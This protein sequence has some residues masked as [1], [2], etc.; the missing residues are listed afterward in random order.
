MLDFGAFSI[1]A[2]DVYMTS[3]T[4]SIYDKRYRDLIN[5]LIEQRKA[6]K[7][8]Q[9][10]VADRLGISRQN[11]SKIETGTRRVDVIELNDWLKALG[12]KVDLIKT[13]MS[14]V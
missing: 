13:V 4:P 5:A 6:K 10:Q 1:I 3:R 12:I 2:Q 8:T 11:I 14:A 9:Q 7:L